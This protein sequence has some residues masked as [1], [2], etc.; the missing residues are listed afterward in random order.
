M[1]SLWCDLSKLFAQL[2]SIYFAHHSRNI[3]SCLLV[4]RTPFFS[5][6]VCAQFNGTLTKSI[7]HKLSSRSSEY[8]PFASTS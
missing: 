1:Q 2:S 7:K 4:I 6:E 8:F 5:R 3:D